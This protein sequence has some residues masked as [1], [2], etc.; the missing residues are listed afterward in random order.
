[1]TKS[2]KKCAVEPKLRFPEF[3][4]ESA[5]AY[6]RLDRLS[7]RVTKKNTDERV[8]QVLTNSAERGVLSQREYFDKD[9]ATKG[10]LDGYYIVE[11]GDF[12]YNPRISAAAP[13][14]PLS[15]SDIDRGVM[16]PLYTVFRFREANTDFYK[17]YFKSTAWH[18]YL[19]SVS[20]TGARH[21]RMSVTNADFM[22]M[23]VPTP[24]ENEQQKIADCLGSLDDLIAA[25]R[26]KLAALR[27]HKQ[28]LMQQLFPREG[29]TRPRVRFPEFLDAP[30]WKE[31][32]LSDFIASLDAGVSV[33]SG[34]R[35]AYET[36]LGI[37]KTSAVTDGV[38]EPME[39]K[40]V[41]EA[42]EL[43]RLK[44]PVQ[45]DSIIISRMNTP[46]LVGA[47][48]YVEGSYANLFLPDRLWAA[49]AK[50]GTFMRFISYILGSGSGRKA[51]S[52]QATGTS[53]SMKNIAKARI[54]K[55]TILVPE[56]SEQ[57]R[58]ANCLSTLD[59]QISA[60]VNKLDALRDH[61][62]GLMQQLFPLLIAPQH[63]E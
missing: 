17:H 44:E 24:D 30:A 27:D 21:D 3:K 57:E 62:C 9:I 53:G 12:V 42:S 40:V 15:R 35:P 23:P 26:R 43:K 1:M 14:G 46:A 55:F 48:A 13:V 19:R 54:F 49:K 50:P 41:A 37:L 22:R 8:T 31:K 6:Q 36:E 45:A 60:Q 34:D 63:D 20:S 52:A 4:R 38:F 18:S 51:L 56:L 7:K 2:D 47:N 10:N 32:P 61:K 5:W 11:N 28:G 58:I 25:E 29:E 33:N 16:S 59:T 39:N